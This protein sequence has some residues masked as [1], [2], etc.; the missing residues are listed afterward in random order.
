MPKENV[1]NERQSEFPKLNL[2]LILPE[3][4]TPKPAVFFFIF[5]GYFAS[6]CN[7]LDCQIKEYAN[8]DAINCGKLAT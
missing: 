1:I 6:A 3:R 4:F 7:M 8:P 5:D 2:A